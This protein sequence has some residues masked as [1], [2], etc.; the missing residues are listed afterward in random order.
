MLSSFLTSDFRG[1]LFKLSSFFSKKLPGV[2]LLLFQN[3]SLTLLLL[4]LFPRCFAV[5]T[6]FRVGFPL[7]DSLN[8]IS[9]AGFSFSIT[10]PARCFGRT[11]ASSNW[12][13]SRCCLAH[14]PLLTMISADNS[15]CR[16][17]FGFLSLLWFR[18]FSHS[19]SSSSVSTSSPA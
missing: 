13:C 17:C 12:M 15:C 4:L 2:Q 6:F 18:V 14:T 16:C 11:A 7:L 8:S 1:Q 3:F 9:V 10:F 19:S 5:L